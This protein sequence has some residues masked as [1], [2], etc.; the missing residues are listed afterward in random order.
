MRWYPPQRATVVKKMSISRASTL[1]FEETAASQSVLLSKLANVA[2]WHLA[3]MSDGRGARPFT[4]KSRHW[5][6]LISP[7][8]QCTFAL[9][10][11]T[12]LTARLTSATARAKT[13][14]ELSPLTEKSLFLVDEMLFFALFVIRMLVNRLRRM[15]RSREGALWRQADELGKS[16]G[17]RGQVGL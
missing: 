13:A 10:F 3:D 4:P 17:R 6:I 14:C 7:P 16:Q 1:D 2:Y 12:L 8:A 15:H 5:L 9:S 11:L